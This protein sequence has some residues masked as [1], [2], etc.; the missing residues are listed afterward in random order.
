MTD[1]TEEWPWPWD[2]P[3]SHYDTNGPK[4]ST[5]VTYNDVP[6]FVSPTGD[7]GIHTA[8]D[9]FHVACLAC[10][11][12]LH[13]NTTSPPSAIKSHKCGETSPP[14]T[15]SLL[16][17]S[18]LMLRIRRHEAADNIGENP[19][20]H[21]WDVREP[22][23]GLVSC[24][25]SASLQQALADG[26][27]ALATGASY[28]KGNPMNTKTLTEEQKL[29]AEH[30]R[31]CVS[32]RPPEWNGDSWTWRYRKPSTLEQQTRKLLGLP[33]GRPIH[34]GED[35]TAALDEIKAFLGETP[36]KAAPEEAPPNEQEKPIRFRCVVAGQPKDVEIDAA[37][38]LEDVVEHV[39]K[40]T[41]NI[42]GR[43][44]YDWELR[45]KSGALIDLQQPVGE[46]VTDNEILF[47]NLRAGVGG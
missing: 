34:S 11:T 39:L 45:R 42:S 25:V 27:P 44:A 29:L 33:L 8:R 18:G 2:K 6:Y 10:K 19:Q 17:G 7:S 15:P 28:E 41:G 5:R 38:L 21:R 26:V 47:L 37:T 23:G 13:H 24:G 40:A 31:E 1:K 14:G 16:M 22:N 20:A 36:E 32:N 12:V 3:V 30:V 9:R 43:P 46:T 4:K 35:M